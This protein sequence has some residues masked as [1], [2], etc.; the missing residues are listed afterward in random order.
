[1]NEILSGK[2]IWHVG[3]VFFGALVRTLIAYQN[4][5]TRTWVG[6]FTVFTISSFTGVVFGLLALQFFPDKV[7][8]GLAITA[9]STQ[10][11]ESGIMFATRRL[12]K[13]ME[14]VT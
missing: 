9:V 5:E 1:M 8:V 11:G 7:F 4:K 6:S 12:R 3:I 2:I 14:S 10:W 13:L